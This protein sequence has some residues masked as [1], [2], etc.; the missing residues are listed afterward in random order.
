MWYLWVL[1]GVFI[2]CGV[3]VL[4]FSLCFVASCKNENLCHL[5]HAIIKIDEWYNL[6][7]S[8]HSRFPET[9]LQIA[10]ELINEGEI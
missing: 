1:L 10:V 8:I 7:G 2:G 5:K 6:K 3:T 9:E 4:T